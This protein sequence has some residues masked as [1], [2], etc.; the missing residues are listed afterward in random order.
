MYPLPLS[1]SLSLSA[2]FYLK[3]IDEYDEYYRERINAL[4]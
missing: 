4:E 2:F 3:R 1:L